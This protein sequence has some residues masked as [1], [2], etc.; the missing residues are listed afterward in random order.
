MR[1]IS[2]TLLLASLFLAAIIFVAGISIGKLID[3][4]NTDQFDQKITSLSDRTNANMLVA[5][6]ENSPEYCPFF[7]EELDN[8]EN[9]T[10]YL[11]YQIAYLEDAKGVQD[12][13][14]KTRYFALELSS[15]LFSNKVRSTCNENFSTVIYFYS[16]KNC[17]LECRDQGAQLLGLKNI[18]GVWVKVYSFDN[19]IGSSSAKLLADKYNVTKYPTVIVN[20]AKYEGVQSKD[21]LVEEVGVAQNNS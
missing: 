9:D 3:T 15:Y 16:N 5:L 14:L 6:L 18:P 17:F 4:G 19:E 10:N 11:G 12:D 7:K 1:Q 20:G 2:I 13:A 8:V 21:Q